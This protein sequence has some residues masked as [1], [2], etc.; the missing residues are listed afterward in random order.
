MH[1]K[2]SLDM[3][4]KSQHYLFTCEMFECRVCEERM[5]RLADLIDHI[6]SAHGYRYEKDG[7]I[8]G[9]SFKN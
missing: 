6:R 1:L 2:G 7:K 3:V 5:L 8:L 4:R 9:I